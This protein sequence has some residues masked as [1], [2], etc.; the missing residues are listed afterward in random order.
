MKRILGVILLAGACLPA[1]AQA[2]EAT[3]ARLADVAGNVLVSREFS[4]ASAGE[5]ARLA[6]GARVLA[7]AN[8]SV[9]VVF[10]D[11]CRVRIAAGER[12]EVDGEACVRLARAGRAEAP[13]QRS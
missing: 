1:A 2:G 10:D 11:G 4:I 8:S 5:A 13:E 9:T 12:F 3:V 7:T 6:P